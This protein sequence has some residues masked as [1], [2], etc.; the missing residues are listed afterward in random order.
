MSAKELMKTN[1]LESYYED[2]VKSGELNVI[3]FVFRME[4]TLEDF[5]HPR[6][7]PA[8]HRQMYSHHHH[9]H[10]HPSPDQPQPPRCLPHPPCS[11]HSYRTHHYHHYHHH[12]HHQARLCA[13]IVM[14]G[15]RRVCDC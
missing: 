4:A 5:S 8:A 11:A 1:E 9:H 7:R 2:L 6:H 14:S 12:H 10:H 3:I 15:C 13:E